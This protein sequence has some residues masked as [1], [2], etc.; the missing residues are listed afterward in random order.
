[1]NLNLGL[2]DVF[3]C[4]DGGYEFVAQ[5]RCAFLSAPSQE[6]CDIRVSFTAGVTLIPWLR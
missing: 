5:K 4:L 6:I 1:M 2:S 3:P